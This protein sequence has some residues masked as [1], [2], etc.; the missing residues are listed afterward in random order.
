MI[1]A[2]HTGANGGPEKAQAP[3]LQNQ[4]TVHLEKRGEDGRMY[5]GSFT[6]K[7]LTI[8]GVGKVGAEIARLNG[9]LPVDQTTEFINT[10]LAHF[11]FAIVAAPEWWN[12][13]ELYDLGIVK[14]VFEALMAHEQSFRAAPSGQGTAPS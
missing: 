13:N 11:K 3:T 2:V 5:A 12:P 7:R 4:K 10:M 8:A 1:E 9:G 6:F 14:E